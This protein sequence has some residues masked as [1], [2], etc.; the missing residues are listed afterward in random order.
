MVKGLIYSIKRYSI[1]DGPGIRQT[2]FFKG[3]PL[4][5]WWCHN[6][7]SQDTKIEYSIKHLMLDGQSFDKTEIIGNYM[8]I[9]EV[10]SEIVKDSIFYDESG[11]GV[12]FSGGEP[13][14][15]HQFLA[16]ILIECR[17]HGIHTTVDTSGYASIG[18]IEQIANLCDLILYDLKHIEN[19]A[20][21]KYTGVS[22]APIL[23]NLKWLD[24][25]RKNVIIRFPVI[26]QVNDNSNNVDKLFDFL[27][28][29]RYIAKIALLP[30]HT[31]AAHK[32]QQLNKQNKME[33][34]NALKAEDMHDIK[35]KLEDIGFE[36]S[37]GN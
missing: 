30:Y 34:I 28:Q 7:E 18:I 16:K 14:M 11:G 27:K 19:D 6:P 36:V 26:P 13:L 15:Q 21:I 37:I 17:K 2:I 3:C 25:N 20:H 8:S 29:L 24:Q 23:N 5:C 22:N 10:M 9:D 35:L 32:Y 31:I 12:T 33:G 1:H 4:D